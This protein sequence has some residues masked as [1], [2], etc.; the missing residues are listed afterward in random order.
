[1]SN[2]NYSSDKFR[3]NPQS[4]REILERIM[5]ILTELNTRYRDLILKPDKNLKEGWVNERTVRYTL[6]ITRPTLL[7]LI[8]SNKIPY[9]KLE[10]SYLFREED[11]KILLE[12]NYINSKQK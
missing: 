8:E 5:A 9:T 11:I 1:M 10:D 6:E 2:T 3:N 7:K 12:S 4:L